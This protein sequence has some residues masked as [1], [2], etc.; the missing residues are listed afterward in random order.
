MNHIEQI[1]VILIFFM[2]IIT[3]CLVYHYLKKFWEILGEEND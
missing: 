2:I 1:L 3:S